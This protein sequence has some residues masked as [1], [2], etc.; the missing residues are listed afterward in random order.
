MID[1]HPGIL[2][3]LD[4]AGQVFKFVSLLLYP[5]PSQLLAIS[6]V[7]SWKNLSGTVTLILGKAHFRQEFE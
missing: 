6:L 5:V 2:D 7:P 4:T 3:V 1:G